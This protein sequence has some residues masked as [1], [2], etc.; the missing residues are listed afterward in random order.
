M[1]RSTSGKSNPLSH[2]MFVL[3]TNQIPLG[4]RNKKR[5]VVKS[6]GKE[7]TIEII[8]AMKE[9]SIN[10]PIGQELEHPLKKRNSKAVKKPE[11]ANESLLDIHIG[12]KKN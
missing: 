4:M 11:R 10:E 3:K 5:T 12:L 1:T 2:P 9:E 7:P 8:K 6:Y